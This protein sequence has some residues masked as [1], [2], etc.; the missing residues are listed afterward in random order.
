MKRKTFGRN[1]GDGDRKGLRR[2]AVL[3][4]DGNGRVSRFSGSQ[5]SRTRDGED[6]RIRGG[7]EIFQSR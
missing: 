5:F 7:E 2:A 4:A 3:T 6:A 1:V